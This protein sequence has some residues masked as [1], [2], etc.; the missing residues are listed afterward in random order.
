MRT[1][2]RSNWVSRSGEC[3]PARSLAILRKRRSCSSIQCRLTSA[4]TGVP[5]LA[6][7]SEIRAGD[8]SV[9]TRRA[10]SGSPAVR[11]SNTDCRFSARA[12]PGKTFFFD[13]HQGDVPGPQRGHEARHRS[14]QTPAQSFAASILR[15]QQYT[16]HRHSQT[17]VP[18]PP[19]SAAGLFRT[20]V[21]KKR[22]CSFQLPHPMASTMPLPSLASRNMIPSSNRS[23][24]YLENKTHENMRHEFI[25]EYLAVVYGM[26]Y[27]MVGRAWLGWQRLVQGYPSQGLQHSE[28]ALRLAQEVA[29]PYNRSTILAD[30]IVAQLLRRESQRTQE[31]A[32]ALIALATER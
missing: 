14:R 11:L 9:N 25:E 2:I 24:Q 4:Q 7:V 12:E 5:L 13:R 3:P 21:H 30:I 22:A 20:G 18:A 1:A 23:T 27:G 10:S 17:A 16:S 15:P 29:H 32:E 6:M 26:D 28:E 19:Q 8:R 31:Q